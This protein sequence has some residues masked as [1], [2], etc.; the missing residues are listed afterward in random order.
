VVFYARAATARRGVPLGVAA[1]EE[2][3]ARRDDLRVVTFGDAAPLRAGF[4]SEHAGVVG[5]E[6]LAG[7]FG[8]GTAGLCLSLTNHSLIPPE[9]LACGMPCVDLDRPST[10]SVYGAGGPVA[11]VPFDPVAIADALQRLLDDEAEWTRRSEAGQALV[12]GSSWDRSAAEVEAGLR[13]ALRR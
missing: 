9:M 2:L 7:L 6:A 13:D 1:L 3:A 10:R 8:S 4:E 11:L 12:A 5:P